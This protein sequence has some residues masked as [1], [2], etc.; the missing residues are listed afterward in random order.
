M[1]SDIILAVDDDEG[2][3]E[4]YRKMFAAQE[5]VEFDVLG[6]AA[7]TGS[8]PPLEC[9]AYDSPKTL[10]GDV[11]RDARRGVHYPL[12]IVDV[13]M[14]EQNGVV[15]VRQLREID[16]EIEII[17]C[18]A[19]PGTVPLGVQGEL[20][21][22]VFFVRKPPVTDEF[23]LMVH[24]LVGY[25]RDRRELRR[26]TAFLTSL[27]ESVADLIFM[28]DTQGVYMTC[29]R[30]FARYAGLAP[31]EIIGGTDGAFL[32]EERCQVY[33]AQDRE[34]MSR[35]IP[36]TCREWVV[37]PD[38]TRCLLETVKSPVCSAAGE[39]IGLIGVGRDI[40]ARAA[41]AGK[42]TAV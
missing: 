5:A 14:P 7:E 33:R 9:R 22:R 25:W 4:V 1:K 15:T 42:P 28:K 40:T 30:T 38:G 8:W 35:G 11:R 16:P 39:C 31:D 36:L 13:L 26:Q 18:T 17:I 6:R 41:A 21:E 12:C 34:V 20:G 32:P 37:L 29:N 24:T 27:L 3:L 10:I 23:V 2:V 19:D